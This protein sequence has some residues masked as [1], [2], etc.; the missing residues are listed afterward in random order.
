MTLWQRRRRAS[1]SAG[2]G[3]GR[4]LVLRVRRR[5]KRMRRRDGDDKCECEWRRREAETDRWA[6]GRSLA[7]LDRGLGERRGGARSVDEKKVLLATIQRH[8][9]EA[10]ALARRFRLL[11]Q[12][13]KAQ[14]E[15]LNQYEHALSVARACNATRPA[16]VA[17]AA[18]AI[19]KRGVQN[20][21]IKSTE[22]AKPSLVGDC[23]ST[24]KQNVWEPC[25]LTT[26]AAAP[27]PI[28]STIKEDKSKE[29]KK[30]VL[31]KPIAKTRSK[32]KVRATWAEEKQKRPYTSMWK[33]RLERRTAIGPLQKKDPVRTEEH[34][35]EEA[36]CFPY[37]EV[38]RNREERKALPGHDCIEC[39]RY[40]NALGELGTVDVAAQKHK[41]SRHRARFEPYQTPDDFWRLSFPDSEP[42]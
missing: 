1:V 38:V 10:A 14:Q 41:C 17:A 15:V 4:A 2:L 6:D 19:G 27:E 25:D 9:Q 26:P 31:F 8:E 30:E 34:I 12:T 39:K 3:V 5:S 37:I 23:I 18:P 7:G 40:Y 35:S 20:T 36:M 29:T 22:I 11:Q 16:E 24:I 28:T 21:P 33:H 13:L 42:Q 32:A